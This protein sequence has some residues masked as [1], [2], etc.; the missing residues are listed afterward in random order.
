MEGDVEEL[1]G[2]FNVGTSFRYIQWTETATITLVKLILWLQASYYHPNL[3][4]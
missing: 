2:L 1:V 4:R 3:H